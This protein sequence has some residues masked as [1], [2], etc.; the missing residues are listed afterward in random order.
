MVAERLYLYRFDDFERF[1][2]MIAQAEARR[3]GILREIDRHNDAVARR[4]RDTIADIEE[5]EFEDVMPGS[6]AAE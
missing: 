3:N 4:V 2:R 1:D 6:E 5:A